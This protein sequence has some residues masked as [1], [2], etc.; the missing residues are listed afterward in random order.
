MTLYISRAQQL[1]A[2]LLDRRWVRHIARVGKNRNACKVLVRNSKE[3][4]L[5]GRSRRI[6]E[7]D[8]EEILGSEGEQ[9]LSCCEHGNE[10]CRFITWRHK[11]EQLA[12]LVAVWQGG[13]TAVAGTLTRV[14]ASHRNY[15]TCHVL[16]P[17]PSRS[18]L[19]RDYL[20]IHHE[21]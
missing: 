9:V 4:G 14:M 3:K 18:P 12:P 2:A 7:T 6:C 8:G 17:P 20:D 10:L 1:T 13:N 16:T 5:L 11:E 15:F 19:Q 21:Y